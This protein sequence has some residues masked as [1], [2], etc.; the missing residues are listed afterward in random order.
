MNKSLFFIIIM[1]VLPILAHAEFM[2]SLV[3]IASSGL[4]LREKADANSKVLAA[5]PFLTKVKLKDKYDTL[6]EMETTYKRKIIEVD[7]IRGYW[8]KVQYEQQTGFMFSG[9]L[10][11]AVLPHRLTNDYVLLNEGWS[12]D[13]S[14]YTNPDDYSFF[15]LY[16]KNSF[17][18][19]LKK[20]TKLYYGNEMSELGETQAFFT[21]RSVENKD[22]SVFVIAI[23]KS[24]LRWNEG[25]LLGSSSLLSDGNNEIRGYAGTNAL[26]LGDTDWAIRT[27]GEPISKKDS[28][29]RT[30]KLIFYKK[31]NKKS[32]VLFNFVRS[33]D[34]IKED[35]NDDTP[36]NP[37]Y[38]LIFQGDIDRDGKLDLIIGT[39]GSVVHE[40]L[41]LSSEA[42]NGNL[43][44]QVAD[45]EIFYCD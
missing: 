21:N 10:S 17:T 32:Q 43:L 24:K 19:E 13:N 14:V 33:E 38:Q 4:R 6:Y 45:R 2:D 3:V 25:V 23:K 16:A 28:R 41:F 18:M 12:C 8:V 15:G 22:T 29:L 1:S 36:F 34:N 39:G 44:K 35:G 40:Y 9:F 5:V 27:E 42:K 30:A 11:S 31:D 37:P 26:P 7:G 20:I